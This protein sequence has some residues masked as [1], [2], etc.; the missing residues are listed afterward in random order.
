VRRPAC[1]FEDCNEAPTV[2]HRD[3]NGTGVAAYAVNLA[4]AQRLWD[5]S[6]ALLDRAAWPLLDGARRSAVSFATG[7]NHDVG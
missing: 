5:V 4:N 7:R 1:D 2:D 6:E 3:A